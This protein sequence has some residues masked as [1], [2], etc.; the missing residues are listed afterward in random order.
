MILTDFLKALAQMGDRRFR[1]VL[2]KG[3]GLTIAFFVAL[4]VGTVSLIRWLVP[5]S[6]SLPFVGPDALS[7]S[8]LSW[9]G[10]GL[11]ILLSVLLM[12]P[13]ASAIT[14]FFLD[15]VADAVEE[16]HHPHL[17]PAQPPG[18]MDVIRDTI[19]F[20]GLILLVNLAAWM[21]LPFFTIAAP[22]LFYILNGFLLGRE[23][24]TLAA[25]RREGR[26]GA[27]AMRKRHRFEIWT[28]GTLMAIP[29]T[30]P[31]LNLIIPIL[32]AAVFTHMYHRFARR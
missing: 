28:A 1:A 20:M 7:V 22:F 18:M 11:M 27:I 15:E 10:V 12:I 9:G 32:G 26:A 25:M 17:R 30:V 19:G 3:I 13:T 24:F 31:V 14:S 6:V 2:F 29:L 23:Y 16:R 21:V 8:L 4:C 5:A